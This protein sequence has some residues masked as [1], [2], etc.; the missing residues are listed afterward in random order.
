MIDMI[1][2]DGKEYRLIETVSSLDTGETQILCADNDGTRF[3][4]SQNLWNSFK[5]FI[6]CILV[7]ALTVEIGKE[8]CAM[9][10]IISSNIKFVK[11]KILS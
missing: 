11:I 2:I 5:R 8:K 7:S 9:Y 4:A 3:V 6:F 10:C 1:K